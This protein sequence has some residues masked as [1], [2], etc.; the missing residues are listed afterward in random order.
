MIRG[1]LYCLKK[2]KLMKGDS[3]SLLEEDAGCN[4]REIKEDPRN[5]CSLAADVFVLTL[6]NEAT[7]TSILDGNSSPSYNW[8]TLTHSS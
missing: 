7:D 3:V 1:L 8:N 6:E 5:I 4:D 2:M